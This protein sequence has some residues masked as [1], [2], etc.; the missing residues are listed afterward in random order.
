MT[1]EGLPLD[2]ELTRD[3]LPAP[4]GSLVARAR[5]VLEGP[6]L[7]LLAVG[8]VVV[9]VTLPLLRG[10]AVRE[11]ERDA[12]R[13]LRLF[14]GE[15]FAAESAA[16]APDLAS[17][18]EGDPVLIRRL[19]DTRVLAEAGRIFHHGYLFELSADEGGE[20][21][22]RAWP[23]AHGETGYAAFLLGES[24]ELMGHRNP[25]A[26]WNGPAQAPFLEGA[27]RDCGWQA[28]PDLESPAL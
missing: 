12:L 25:A 20:R 8:T 26:R 17:L 14:G 3:A 23:Y 19:P 5:R 27:P 13:T 4:P 24:G 21:Y 28:L 16:T 15:V 9:L 2:P 10:L 6:Q 11:N 1:M 22:L 7:L 18:V